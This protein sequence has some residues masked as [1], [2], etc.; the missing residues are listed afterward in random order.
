[1]LHSY[2]LAHWYW[3][4][5]KTDNS[6]IRTLVGIII[7]CRKKNYVLCD[8]VAKL[9]L[10]ICSTIWKGLFIWSSIR[11][12]KRSYLHHRED[13]LFCPRLNWKYFL[14]LADLF[15]KIKA[16]CPIFIC[17]FALQVENEYNTVQPA[18]KES[19]IRY[20]E[21]AGNMAV[22]QKTGVPWIMC[23]QRD[24]PDPVVRLI[25]RIFEQS[26]ERFIS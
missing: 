2:T 10:R 20:V 23:K 25:F 3:N 13:P 6:Q 24:A 17:V 4:S 18:F 19:G 11:W 21:W 1:M 14:I 26:E 7:V 22:G 5:L 9:K 16:F 12:E 8:I 15:F